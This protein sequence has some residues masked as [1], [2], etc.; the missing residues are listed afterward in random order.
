MAAGSHHRVRSFRPRGAFATELRQLI[1]QPGMPSVAALA[2]HVGFNRVRLHQILAETG[3]PP[4]PEIVDSLSDE[5]KVSK[6][7]RR[8]LHW[9]A[10]RD[11]AEPHCRVLLELYEEALTNAWKTKD[12]FELPT[13]LGERLR[14]ANFVVANKPVYLR[15]CSAPVE[16][17]VH[18]E[19]GK[20]RRSLVDGWIVRVEP[21][22]MHK[23][24]FLRKA[25]NKVVLLNHGRQCRIGWM[26][27][28]SKGEGYALRDDEGRPLLPVPLLP[29]PHR[30]SVIPRGGATQVGQP[31]VEDVQAFIS[32]ETLNEIKR[33]RLEQEKSE[34]DRRR[35]DLF[36]R[37]RA[38]KE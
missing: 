22:G 37:V 21:A 32:T 36:D 29:E 23:G 33:L 15:Q 24:Q 14:L 28:H 6:G 10:V 25:L 9:L 18:D 17:L 35:Q 20:M 4:G 3:P 38:V 30:R 2:Q 19:D 31:S 7:Q 13:R 27:R 16:V 34:S 26:K 8:R 5:L 11:R 12:L 1:E